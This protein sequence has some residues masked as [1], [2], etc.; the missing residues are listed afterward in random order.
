VGEYGQSNDD[1]RDYQKL[2]VKPAAAIAA[3]ADFTVEVTYSTGFIDTF[4]ARGESTQGFSKS[5][6]G[7]GGAALGEPFGSTYWFPNNNTPA[8]GALYTISLTA[9]ASFTSA[10]SGNRV[11]RTTANNS[12]TSVWQINTPTAPYQVFAAFSDNYL[13]FSSQG[14]GLYKTN[15]ITTAD[16]RELDVYIYVNKTIYNTNLNRNRD[17]IDLFINRLPLYIREIEKVAGAYPG[18]SAGFVFDDL[19]NGSG[20]IAG[21]GA[22]ETKDRPFYTS[23]GVTSEATFV[24]EYAH[25]W[26]GNSVRPASWKDLWLN[27]GFATYVTDLFYENT[28]GISA[29]TKYENLYNSTGSSSQLWAAATADIK[30]ESDLFGGAKV[31]Y[32]RGSLTLAALR[33]SLGDADFFRILKNWNNA[34]STAP[35]GFKGQAA[36][37]ADFITFAQTVSGKDLRAFTQAWLYQ[38]RKPAS[39]VWNF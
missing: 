13:E 22:V 11:S 37:T 24:H 21:W 15:K 36:T 30:R 19:S 12:T 29:R 38:T 18:E 17:K 10:A 28:Q 34:A 33:A 7:I 23:S 4:V 2:I 5:R 20:G 9:P 25:Q 1:E 35:A 32:N 39:F 6:S 16:G 31:A 8:D 26:F 27:E 3:G 14:S